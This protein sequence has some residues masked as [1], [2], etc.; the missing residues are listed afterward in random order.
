M[1]ENIGL[2]FMRKEA[3]DMNSK[4]TIEG[5]EFDANWTKK[6]YTITCNIGDLRF[7]DSCHMM[8]MSPK[9]YNEEEIRKRCEK[10]LPEYI[11]TAKI[12]TE[13]KEL[14]SE[15]KE[16]LSKIKSD[17]NAAN[18]KL[19]SNRKQ[20]KKQLKEG[21]L[22]QKEYQAKISDLKNEK[23]EIIIKSRDLM[24]NLAQEISA[25]KPQCSRLIYYYLNNMME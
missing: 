14:L 19:N 8:Y 9:S 2:V 17:I 11:E 16:F 4:I 25:S 22:T 24:I 3:I 7:K 20:L 21:I 12:I 18:D 1:E 10:L 13:N 15:K 23:D 5:I 6:D